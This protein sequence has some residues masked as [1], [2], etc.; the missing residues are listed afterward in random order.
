MASVMA[1]M[2]RALPNRILARQGN[3]TSPDRNDLT[4]LKP[5][6]WH[7]LLQGSY[8]KLPNAVHVHKLTY[9][10]IRSTVIR[11]SRFQLYTQ[12]R[13]PLEIFI[14]HQR[15]LRIQ[16]LSRHLFFQ[17]DRFRL[18]QGCVEGE[19]SRS[20]IRRHHPYFWMQEITNRKLLLPRHQR[21][22]SLR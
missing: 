20:G 15:L 3:T 4:N 8:G 16:Y 7:N 1:T 5:V 9:R 14:H 12:R 17:Q 22:L 2:V 18:Y 13:R 21:H 6:D 11:K 19:R 10:S